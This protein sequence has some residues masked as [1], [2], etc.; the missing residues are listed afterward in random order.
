M[1]RESRLLCRVSKIMDVGITAF[2]YRELLSSRPTIRDGRAHPSAVAARLPD[3][4]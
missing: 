1:T 2:D 3:E 4:G